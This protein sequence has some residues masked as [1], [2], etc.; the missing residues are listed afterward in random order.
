MA[1]YVLGCCNVKGEACGHTYL[2]GERKNRIFDPTNDPKNATT[3]DAPFELSIY[4]NIDQ[5]TYLRCGNKYTPSVDEAKSMKKLAKKGGHKLKDAEAHKILYNTIIVQIAA[6]TRHG[7]AIDSRF[8]GEGSPYNRTGMPDIHKSPVRGLCGSIDIGC[9]Q[10]RAIIEKK[11]HINKFIFMT[12]SLEVIDIATKIWNWKESGYPAVLPPGVSEDNTLLLRHNIRHLEGTN[13][14]VDVKLWKVG[15]EYLT[16]AVFDVNCR[17]DD[18]NN[19]PVVRNGS[20][21]CS[22]CMFRAQYRKGKLAA[23]GTV[24]CR[25]PAGQAL[26]ARCKGLKAGDQFSLTNNAGL[27]VKLTMKIDVTA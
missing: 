8:F 4:D 15:Q 3:L 7:D 18:L 24:C 9:Q 13:E 22:D 20:C 16:G 21:W 26:L 27:D 1:T 5:L 23:T 12:S 11:K 25:C 10:I 14:G 17:F 19:V 2:I 6:R